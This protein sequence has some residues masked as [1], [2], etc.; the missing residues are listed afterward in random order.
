[1]IRDDPAG[2]INCPKMPDLIIGDLQ[3]N[4]PIIQGGM[5]VRISTEKLVTAV[6]R[7][8]ALGV[9]AGIGL[10]EEGPMD[11]PFIERSKNA[12]RAMIKETKRNGAKNL[13][14]NLMVALTNYEDL[15]KVAVEEDV[16]VI[17]SGAGLPLRLPELTKQSN[18]KLIPIVSS[19]RAADI[20]CKT[21]LRKFDRLPDAIVLEGPLAGGHLGFDLEQL[22]NNET[23]SIDKLLTNLLSVTNHFENETGKEIP[24]IVAGG[25]FDGK[26]IARVF[27]L[28]AKGVQIATRFVCTNECEVAESF[29]QAYINCKKDDIDIILSPAGMPARVISTDL[30][31]RLRNEERQKFKCAY[32]CLRTCD[33]RKV[34]YCLAQAMVNAYRGD[35]ANGIVMCGADTYKI[36][37]IVSVKELID[38]LCEGYLKEQ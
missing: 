11:V 36:N 10:G 34:K 30:V 27:K 23:L 7:E 8:G 31:K 29:K 4:P 38:E 1:M 14:I 13:G 2:K 20:I 28:G 9:I 19:A 15:V 24:I 32:K 6:D 25:I 18:A 37:K 33:P 16:D 35:V 5:G 17:I 3:I 21:W 22:K 26:D 12:L